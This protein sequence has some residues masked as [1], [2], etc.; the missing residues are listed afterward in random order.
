MESE[1]LRERLL[2][3]YQ[4]GPEAVVAVVVALMGEMVSQQAAIGARVATLAAE[5][6]TLRARL[7]RNSHNSSKPPSSDGPEVKPHPQSQRVRSGRKPGG[8]PG[9]V[10]QTLRLV[11][12]PD[13]VVV[14]APRQCGICGQSLEAVAASGQER[15][16]VV[17]LPPLR[18][19]VVEHQAQRKCCL[20]CGAE[21][22][23]AF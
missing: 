4:A 16:Q 2:Q 5:N 20:G 3:A 9:H 8:Q 18:V 23:G 11:A 21:T 12:T 14:H 10:G 17:D 22:T 19:W 6:A 7:D 1:A 15:R 13:A